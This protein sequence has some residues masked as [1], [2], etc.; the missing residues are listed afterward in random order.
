[1]NHHANIGMRVLNLVA[2][3]CEIRLLHGQRE[4][5]PSCLGWVQCPPGV[6]VSSMVLQPVGMV[7]VPPNLSV[8][9][10][11]IPLNLSVL[12]HRIDLSWG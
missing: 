7:R 12:P 6:V 10:H 11:G 2:G 1:M 9:P 8:L 5:G 4:V 3:I